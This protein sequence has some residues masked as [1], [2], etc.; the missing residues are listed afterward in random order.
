MDMDMDMS[1]TTCFLAESWHISSNGA[2][3]ATCIGTILLVMVMEAL[4]RLG[5]EYDEWISRGFQAR[6]ATVQPSSASDTMLKGSTKQATT[7]TVTSVGLSSRTIIFRASPLQQVTRSIL[8]AVTLGVAYI[9]M[10]LVMS[11]NGYV[12]ICVLI[13]GGLG[14][15]FCDW[16]TRR[17]VVSV[18]GET[19]SEE[20]AAGLE[21]PSVCCS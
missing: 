6:A 16:M 3:A 13:G 15:F 2:F 4:R 1:T 8:H 11:Y 7:A 19:G 9:V 12:I 21:E 18:G 17:I 20:G 10:L 14:K 5:K